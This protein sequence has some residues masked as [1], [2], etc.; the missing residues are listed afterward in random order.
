MVK[1][2]RIP[3]IALTTLLL[4]AF[5][6]LVALSAETMHSPQLTFYAGQGIDS[7][8]VDIFPKVLRGDLKSDDTYLYALGYF[9]PLNTPSQLQSVFDFLAIPNTYSGIEAVVGKHE[10]LQ[11]NWEVDANWQLRFAPLHFGS[12]EVRPGIGLGGSYALGRPGYEDGSKNDPEKRYR[13]QNFNIYELEWSLPDISSFSLVSRIHH[14]SG[15][16]GLIAPSHVGSNFVAV[17]LRYS[18]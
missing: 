18:Y 2:Y 1:S 4:L 11:Y 16:Y 14:R 3:I 17:G 9:H 12:L 7:N 6:P 13:F 8:L 15:M 10:G 5:S